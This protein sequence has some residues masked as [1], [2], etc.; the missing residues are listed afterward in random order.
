VEQATDHLNLRD[1]DRGALA[2][3]EQLVRRLA[4]EAAASDPR[5]RVEV[6]VVEAYRNMREYLRQH[7]QVVAAAEEAV[8]RAGLEP[9]LSFVR[10]GTDGSRLSAR[11]LPTPNI[12]TGGEDLHSRHEWICVADMGVA[13]ATIVHLAQIWAE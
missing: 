1:F 4:E 5:A 11:G 6:E 13:V 10:G 12:F 8:R 7:P 3:H 9:T 2:A